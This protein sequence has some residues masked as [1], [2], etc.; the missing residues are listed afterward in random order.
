MRCKVVRLDEIYMCTEFHMNTC[1]Y[2]WATHQV[3]WCVPG[4]AVEP[5][6]HARVPASSS[7]LTATGSNV[8]ANF[9]E[10]LTMLSLPKCPDSLKITKKEYW[11]LTRCHGNSILDINIPFRVSHRPCFLQYSDEVWSKLGKSKMVNSKHFENHTLPAASW[12]R[13]KLCLIIVTSMRSASYTEQ[14][15]ELW[16]NQTMY[17]DFIRHFLSLNSR[18]TSSPRHGQTVWDIKNPS[19]ILASPMSWDHVHRVWCSVLK[20]LGGVFPNSRACDF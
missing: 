15:T 14:T 20:I 13:Y 18:H 1:K 2:V 11:G 9:Q 6:C 4:G 5:L 17:V 8:C 19:A 3:F 16:S 10:F 12:W 7:I